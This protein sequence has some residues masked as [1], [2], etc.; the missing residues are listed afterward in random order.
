MITQAKRMAVI[1][2][3]MAKGAPNADEG[4]CISLW[5]ASVFNGS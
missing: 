2:L 5:R 1:V 3:V 4:L